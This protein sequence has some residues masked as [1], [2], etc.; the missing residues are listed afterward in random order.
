MYKSRLVPLILT[1]ACTGGTGQAPEPAKTAEAPKPAEPDA[2]LVAMFKP[3]PEDMATDTRPITPERVALGKMLYFD[4]RLSKNHDISCNSCH[5]LDKFGVDNEPTSPGH[6]GARGDRNSPTVYNAAIH[7]AQ[8][9]DGR[10]PDVEAQAK[11]PILNPVEMA[12]PDE[13]TV[14]ATLSSIPGYVDAFAAAFPDA[15]PAVTYDNMAIAIGAFERTLVTPSKW[16]AYLKGDASALT[17]E[18]V[19]G[20]KVFVQ[21][22]CT[23]CHLGPG[24]GG[25]MYQKIGLVRP[26]ETEDVGRF[27]VTNAESDRFVF[28]VPSLRNVAETGPYFHDGSVATLEEATRLMAS[29]QLGRDLTDV[30]VGKITTFLKTL[31]GTPSAD[32][33]AEPTL[34]ESGPKTRKPDPS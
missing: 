18:E 31:T 2:Q 16:D 11:G 14:V 15:K 32:L 20:A 13:A 1:L 5:M 33:I 23:T 3:L 24:L 6:R 26:Y 19:D 9:W 4:K 12:M 29:H 22:G 30:E 27:S 7:L 8:F 10:E 21:T 34:P 28:K 25:M 17:Q